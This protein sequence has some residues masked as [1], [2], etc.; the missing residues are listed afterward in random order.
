MQ[1]VTHF[2]FV[3]GELPT[4]VASLQTTV[5]QLYQSLHDVSQR[6]GEPASFILRG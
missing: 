5:Q 4:D 3:D 2:V 1:K 6:Y